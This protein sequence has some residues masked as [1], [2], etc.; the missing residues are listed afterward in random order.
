M[1]KCVRRSKIDKLNHMF[2]MVNT[3]DKL[4]FEWDWLSRIL[5]LRCHYNLSIIQPVQETMAGYV[6]RCSIDKSYI[7]WLGIKILELYK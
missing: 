4:F 2:W 5:G 1:W 3:E 7:T 6:Y